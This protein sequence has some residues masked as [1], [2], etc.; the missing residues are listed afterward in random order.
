MGQKVRGERVSQLWKAA[1][2]VADPESGR[3][4]REKKLQAENDSQQQ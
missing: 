3:G 1:K 4:G 2:A